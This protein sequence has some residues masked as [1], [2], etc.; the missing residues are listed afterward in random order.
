MSARLDR[1]VGRAAAQAGREVPARSVRVGWWVFAYGAAGG[2]WAR[3]V[4]IGWLPQGWV[5]F[6][7]RHVDGRRG[8]VEASPSYPTSYLSGETARRVG[9]VGGGR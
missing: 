1:S 7:L 2:S 9:L 3:V 8:V 6:E 4:A 5:R